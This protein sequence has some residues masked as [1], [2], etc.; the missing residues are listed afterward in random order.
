[1]MR[2]K[3][4]DAW[5]VL[6]IQGEFT[7]GFDTFSELGPCVSVFGSARTTED[8]Q[9]YLEARLFGELIT[10]E[11]FGVITGGGPGIMEAANRGAHESG[12]KSIGVG[13]ELP[14][15]AS[16][17]KYVDLGVDNRYFFTRKV[18]FLKY[19]QAFVIFP[20]GVGTLDELF[21]AITLAQCGHN[22]KYP[23][24]LVGTKFWSGLI[25]WMKE[26]LVSEGTIS[27]KDFDL[28]RI[29]DSAAEARDKIMEYHNKYMTTPEYLG[30]KTNF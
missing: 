11:G 24:V 13:I 15:E 12:G 10:R 25:D 9:W 28:F 14:F 22:V 5:Q 20:G 17:N 16:M 2:D 23:I 27:E 26:T 19:S 4:K 7:K 30:P 18:M 21:E 8:N 1:M 3:S 6:R 29:V